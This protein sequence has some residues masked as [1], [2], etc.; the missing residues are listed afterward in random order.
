M[1][2]NWGSWGGTKWKKSQVAIILVL[3]LA[4][5]IAESASATNWYAGNAKGSVYGVKANIKTPSTAPYIETSVE[6]TW[7]S[8]PCCYW[9]QA[10]WRYYKDWPSAQRYVEYRNHAGGG[11]L[12]PQGNQSWGTTVE[13]KVQH[14]S[15]EMWCAY[16]NGSSK[17]CY[18][19]IRTAPSQVQAYSEVHVSSNNQLNTNFS[20]VSYR[21]SSGTW[22]LLNNANWRE[23]PPY[24]VDKYANYRY[25][26][27]GPWLNGKS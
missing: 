3:I 19:Y 8:L 9:V 15:G 14:N 18:N 24:K 10:G 17:G 13:Y 1:V 21:N 12:I 7:V 26:T 22:Y 23:D 20:S 25:R 16:I 2:L 4:F 11:D 27:Y 6:S 5:G